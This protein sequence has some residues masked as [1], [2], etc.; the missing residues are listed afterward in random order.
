MSFF[1]EQSHHHQ[2][3][4][5]SLVTFDH[6]HNYD[7][8]GG[9]RR[10]K[11]HLRTFFNLRQAAPTDH[12]GVEIPKPIFQWCK[13]PRNLLQ[14]CLSRFAQ[15]STNALTWPR[16]EIQPSKKGKSLKV[17]RNRQYLW[18]TM[19]R[20]MSEKHESQRP[21]SVSDSPQF[22][23]VLGRGDCGLTWMTGCLW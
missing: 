10:L 9:E 19:W 22:F 14:Y 7:R 15:I 5:I 17:F 21:C 11:M 4:Y 1:C 20:A 16:P 12:R 8:L 3:I 13:A 23:L 6:H 18:S 2:S